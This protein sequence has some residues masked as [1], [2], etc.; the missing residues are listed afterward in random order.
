MPLPG[1]SLQRGDVLAEKRPEAGWW[2]GLAKLGPLPSSRPDMGPWSRTKLGLCRS[3][4]GLSFTPAASSLLGPLG[5]PT[6]SWGICN[7]GKA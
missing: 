6:V 1:P 4:S 3:A 5:V 2:T 7:W